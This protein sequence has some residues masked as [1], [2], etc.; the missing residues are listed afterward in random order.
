MEDTMKAKYQKLHTV[1]KIAIDKVTKKKLLS[2]IGKASK[3]LKE[4]N[5]INIIFDVPSHFVDR[6]LE[7]FERKDIPAIKGTAKIAM[8]EIKETGK[9]IRYYSSQYNLWIV[10]EKLGCNKM[11][12]VT[13]YK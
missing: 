6:F 4:K 13:D 12:F 7:R 9:V 8:Q 2:A 3:E 5:K 11:R 1:A 10:L